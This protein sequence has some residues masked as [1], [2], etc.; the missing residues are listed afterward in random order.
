MEVI[1]I[2]K[3]ILE[4][5]VQHAREQ[6]PFECCGL[7]MGQSDI[8]THIQRMNNVLQSPVRYSMNPQDLF[9]FFKELRSLQ[10][11]HLGIYHSHPASEA[12]PSS[13]DVEQAYY[14][15]C[16]YFITSLKNPLSPSVRAFT[17]LNDH[18][19]EREFQVIE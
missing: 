15:D 2:K 8:I 5:I 18:I 13:I 10:L 3:G 17:I 9:F 19:L 11:K 16:I 1:T 14:P 7:L 4:T 12:Y 6:A